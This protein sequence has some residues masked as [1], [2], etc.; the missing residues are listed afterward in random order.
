MDDVPLS[1]RGKNWSCQWCSTLCKLQ[2]KS[3]TQ[4]SFGHVENI[5]LVKLKILIESSQKISIVEIM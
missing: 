5:T 1:N 2:N 4:L 3:E